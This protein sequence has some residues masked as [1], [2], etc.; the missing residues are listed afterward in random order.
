MKRET[1]EFYQ[2]SAQLKKE[3]TRIEENIKQHFGINKIEDIIYSNANN[4]KQFMSMLR[5]P[6]PPDFRDKRQF[7]KYS[8]KVLKMTHPDRLKDKS[9]REKAIGTIQFRTIT[10]IKNALQ[11][12][13]KRKPHKKRKVYTGKRGGKY[14][15]INGKKRYI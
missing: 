10:A 14:H 13:G 11:N 5:L 1:D 8:N 6:P 12:G 15:L 2:K 9:I 7:K 3:I 4:V